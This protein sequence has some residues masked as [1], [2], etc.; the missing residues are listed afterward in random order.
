MKVKV[1]VKGQGQRPKVKGK[2][3]AKSIYKL[4][5]LLSFH[6]FAKS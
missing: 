2:G 3:Q 4:N 6:Y 5:P 1:K